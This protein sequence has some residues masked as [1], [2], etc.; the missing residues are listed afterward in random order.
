VTQDVGV[1][2]FF[3]QGRAGLRGD[4]D[5]GAEAL[6]DGVAAEAP[7][8]AGA[9][10]RI[11]RPSGAFLQ[12]G[13][14]QLLNGTVERDGAL[15]AALSL[16]ADRCTVA[17]RDVRA[18]Q[19][20]EFGDTQAGLDG[21]GQHGLVAPAFPASRIRCRQQ[22]VAFIGGQEGDG[23]LVEPLGR[24]VQDAG[25]EQGMLWVLERGEGEQGADRG[26]ADVAG[27]GAVA[28]LVLQ[29]IEERRDHVCGPPSPA[30]QE[31]C[32]RAAGR[33]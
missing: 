25:D 11:A 7:S 32:R 33:R 13:A 21:Q 3:E 10:Q 4:F 26:Q 23:P 29:M 30:S 18:V 22:R 5:V 15:F 20:C 27:P 16:A 12:P 14:Q 28:A 1:D 2:A 6:G 19:A 9:E 17:E 31:A 8:G 24:D